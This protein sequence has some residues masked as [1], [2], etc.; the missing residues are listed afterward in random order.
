MK[1]LEGEQTAQL[2]W[3]YIDVQ[4]EIISLTYICTA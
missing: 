4:D 1:K 2:C 3:K